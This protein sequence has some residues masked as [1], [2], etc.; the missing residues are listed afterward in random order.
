[1]HKRR[2]EARTPKAQVRLFHPAISDFKSHCTIHFYRARRITLLQLYYN[3]VDLE[4]CA[5]CQHTFGLRRCVLN[6]QRK[7][8]EC[9]STN[10]RTSDDGSCVYCL[11]DGAK[12]EVRTSFQLELLP[13]QR[14]KPERNGVRNPEIRS[15]EPGVPAAAQAAA[16]A[17]S[18]DLRMHWF[19]AFISE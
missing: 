15:T 18:H 19:S 8:R 14:T 4:V 3:S 6:N 9:P 16:F 17:R 12:Y 5:P 2:P 10:V 1:M 11:R 13:K 7:V